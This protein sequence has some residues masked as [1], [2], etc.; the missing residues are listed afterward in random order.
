VLL[1]YA[2]GER[3][4]TQS[5][6]HFKE[7]VMS[8]ITDAGDVIV[9]GCGPVGILTA[10]ALSQAGAKVTVIEAEPT[11][12]NSPRAMCYFGSTILVLDELGLKEDVAAA[13]V[14]VS[15]FT[16][17][18][19]DLKLSVTRDLEPIADRTVTYDLNCGQDKIVEIALRHAVKAG[20]DV[21]FSTSLVSF[22]QDANGVTALVNT[23]D[24]PKKLRSK[25]LVGADGARS[26]VRELMNVEFEGHTWESYFVANNIYC[27]MKSLGFEHSTYVCNPEYGGVVC[28]IDD[29][30]LWRVTYREDGLSPAETFK[31]RQQRKLENL[32]PKGVKYEIASNSPYR[33]HQRCASSLREGRVLLTGDAGHITNPMGGLGLTTGVWSG[34]ILADLLGAV[35][36]GEES[37]EILQR[38]SDERRHIFW[39]HTSPGATETKRMIEEADDARRRQDYEESRTRH[40]RPQELIEFLSFPFNIIG[41][42]IRLGSRWQNANPF[43]LKTG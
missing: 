23:P 26:K 19:P 6:C 3:V 11:W 21:K 28:I 43:A 2:V 15:G 30:D 14:K 41:D 34:M 29:N 18:W 35:L 9:V 12:S 33:V 17:M 27:D 40:E 37:D 20:V 24:G 4:F 13:S 8:N 10:H 7:L 22:E 38:Y 16:E 25:Y 5:Q 32:I 39:K 36:K 42:P 31:D 1:P